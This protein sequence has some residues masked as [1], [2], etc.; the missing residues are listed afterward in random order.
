MLFE[1]YYLPIKRFPRKVFGSGLDHR[2]LK[3]YFSKY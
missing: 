2:K 3:V 1:T